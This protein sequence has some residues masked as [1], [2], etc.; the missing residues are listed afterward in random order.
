[1]KSRKI[2]RSRMF[3]TWMLALSVVTVLNSC[4]KDDDDDD[5]GP[6]GPPA[7][8]V[9]MQNTAFTPSTITVSAGTTITWRNKDNMTHTVTSDNSAFTSSGN[10]SNGG[11]HSFQFNTA[12]TFP[13]HCAPHPQMTGTVVVQ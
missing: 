7:N 5:N 6:S 13:Y 1:M 10:L 9:W 2:F 3:M 11:T 8:E 4:D 12:G